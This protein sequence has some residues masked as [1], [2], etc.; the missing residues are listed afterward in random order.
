MC[1]ADNQ[2]GGRDLYDDGSRPWHE[3][4]TALYSGNAAFTSS[5][6]SPLTF[7]GLDAPG[8]PATVSDTASNGNVI[9]SWT[10]PSIASTYGLPILGYTAI[11]S[12]ANQYGVYPSCTV[13]GTA[14]S[15]TAPDA[16]FNVEQ[17][18]S[19]T[20]TTAGGTGPANVSGNVEPTCRPRRPV[21][22]PH[23][24]RHRTPARK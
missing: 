16:A 10:P 19:V 15:C 6:S 22:L 17:T 8:A 21:S 3:L 13:A 12:V 20:A 4:L 2:L 24:Y 5:T 23:W 7:E 14:S 9:V 18:F 1:G 11:G